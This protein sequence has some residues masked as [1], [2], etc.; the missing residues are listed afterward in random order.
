MAGSSGSKVCVTKNAI[1]G[2]RRPT[3]LVH[4]GVELLAPLGGNSVVA[5]AP[6]VL[7]R[8][9]FGF[10]PSA[11]D[12]RLEGRV[13]RALVD[14]EDVAGDLAELEGQSPAVHGLRAEEFER[15]HLER[16]ANDLGALV[17]S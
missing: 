16:A 10:D 15:E 8:A 5:R 17:R 4:L 9:P 3:P 12:H 1:H 13:E 6:V 2:G 14:V 7:A 11:P